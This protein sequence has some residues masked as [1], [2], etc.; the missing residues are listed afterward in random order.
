MHRSEMPHREHGKFSRTIA[1]IGLVG[2][3]AKK[4]N[5]FWTMAIRRIIRHRARST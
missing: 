3:A 5:T 1:A 2:Q 4:C